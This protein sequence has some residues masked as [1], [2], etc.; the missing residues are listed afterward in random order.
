MDWLTK[1]YYYKIINEDKEI[2]AFKHDYLLEVEKFIIKSQMQIQEI[3]RIGID[4]FDIK[5]VCDKVWKM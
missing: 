4:N 2:I 1:K 3:K 5:V